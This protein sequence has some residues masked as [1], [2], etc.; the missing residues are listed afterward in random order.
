MIR[1][2]LLVLIAFFT[3]A[4]ESGDR[5][6]VSLVVFSGHRLAEDAISPFDTEVQLFAACLNV[7]QSVE[8]VCL[9]VS[10]TGRQAGRQAGL[11]C[12]VGLSIH[13]PVGLSVCPSVR[14][15][16]CLAASVRVRTSQ[17]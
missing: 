12:I 11:Q 13:L 3:L 10:V 4:T 16:H 9:F 2:C 15:C 8:S 14:P 17:R 1:R 5:A 6:R 7:S